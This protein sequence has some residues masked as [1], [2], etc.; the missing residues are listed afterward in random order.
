MAKI[1]VETF[2]KQKPAI[3][4]DLSRS[5]DLHKISTEKTKEEAVAGVTS[6]L[7]GLN[8]SVTWQAFHLFKQRRFTSKIT[9]YD[10]PFSFIDQMQKGDLKHFLHQHLFEKKDDG[11]LMKD[12]I[13]LEAPF[14]FV[15]KFFMWIFLKNYFEKFVVER[16]EIITSFAETE[17]WKLILKHN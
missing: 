13:S 11:T 12:V 3:V 17:K 15:G 16:N 8:E 4:F 14:G 6:G 1:I 5:I 7:I 2:I 9:Q 10:F